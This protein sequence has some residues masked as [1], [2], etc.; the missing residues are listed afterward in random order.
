M[1]FQVQ[2]RKDGDCIEG[3]RVRIEFGGGSEEG[4]T[5]AD[6]FVTFTYA[7]PGPVTIWV[8]DQKRGTYDYATAQS[9]TVML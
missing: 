7:Q 4:R 8:D 3:S 2:I 9:V 5:D 1:G 6:G